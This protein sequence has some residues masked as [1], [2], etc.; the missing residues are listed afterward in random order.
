MRILLIIILAIAATA[1]AECMDSLWTQVSGTADSDHGGGIT[2]G[3]DGN[4][5]VAGYK[6]H[7]GITA[8]L[9]WVAK[10]DPATGAEIWSRTYSSGSNQQIFLDVERTSDGGYICGGWARKSTDN[11]QDYWIVRLNSAG[12][13][14]WSRKYGHELSNQGTCVAEAAGGFVIAGR[15][16]TLPN[17]FG[18]TDWWILKVN[19]NGDSI[20]SQRMGNP[21]EDTCYDIVPALDDGHVLGGRSI[22]DSTG[23]GRMAQVNGG[24]I[25]LWDRLYEFA[26]SVQIHGILPI[27]AGYLACGAQQDWNANNKVMWMLVDE[28][29]FLQWHQQFDVGAV[30]SAV[31]NS[32]LAD[33][34]GGYYIVGHAGRF[35]TTNNDIFALH[36]SGCGDSLGLFWS[37]DSTGEEAARAVLTGAGQMVTAGVRVASGNQRDALVMAFSA[38]TCNIPPCAFERVRPFDESMPDIEMPF[39]LNWTRSRDSDN[40]PVSYIFHIEH[41]Y[42]AGAVYPTD[43]VVTDTFVH[44]QIDLPVL[45]LDEIFDFYWR[46]WATD[47]VDT[48]EAT[49]GQ[50][51][52]QLDITTDADE[53]LV[54]PSSFVLSAYPNPFNPTS[55]LSFTLAA[56]Q[57]VSLALY[58]VQGRMTQQLVN[59]KMEAGSHDVTVDGS[60]LTSGIYFARLNAGTQ[61]RVAKLVLMK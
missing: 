13:T 31:G 58:D 59:G 1:N 40:D 53:H 33:G 32:L 37:S 23:A 51:H 41:N 61:S 18:G 60:A 44:L 6:S 57:E 14:L 29:G 46:V 9:G 28:F 50:G 10:Y 48:V 3:S 54:H 36:I 25:V 15:A 27:E 34:L 22:L 43:T 2:L 45:P 19:S 21:D 30:G 49:D 47:G 42:L 55:T 52:F 7:T 20:W 35:T 38:D 5:V 11:D 12:D 17:G 24:G 26:P 4:V 56:P 16:H 8:G 39:P